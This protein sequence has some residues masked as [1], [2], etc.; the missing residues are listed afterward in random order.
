MTSA[1][2]TPLASPRRATGQANSI[3]APENP[4][5]RVLA[6]R[7]I[8][9]VRPSAEGPLSGMGQDASAA[10]E[11]PSAGTRFIYIS[12]AERSLRDTRERQI[13]AIAAFIADLERV[14]VVSEN[15]AVGKIVKESSD[16]R[17]GCVADD[18]QDRSQR[19]GKATAIEKGK[20]GSCC[21]RWSMAGSGAYHA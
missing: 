15:E 12:T 17:R 2:R 14:A 20:V 11:S 8:R 7:V 6:S 21:R 1:R 18:S 4:A 3:L 19:Y 10:A 5:R 13:V 9:L 16:W